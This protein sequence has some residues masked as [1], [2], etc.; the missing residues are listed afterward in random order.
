MIE[1]IFRKLGLDENEYKVFISLYKIGVN[2]ASVIARNANLER[3]TAYKILKRLYK[4]GLIGSTTRQNTQMFFVEDEKTLLRFVKN[5]KK[6]LEKIEEDYSIIE[7]EFKNLRPADIT[8]PK[9]KI[10]EESYS[11]NLKIFSD[12]LHES[13]TQDLTTIRMIASDT[14][15]E[16]TG[17]YKLKDMAYLFLQEIKKNNIK[18]D[19]MVAEGMLTRERLNII[20][21]FKDIYELPASNDATNI[22]IVGDSIFLII[23]KENIIG[24]QIKHQAIAQTMHFLFDQLKGK[25]L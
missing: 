18:I 7:S 23:Y 16:Q 11:K 20:S 14:F 19:N 9:I 10:Y 12:I 8:P 22:F 21:Q 13:L 25:V 5:R 17:K 15:H 2:P 24:V 6:E 1:E 3:T 4:L